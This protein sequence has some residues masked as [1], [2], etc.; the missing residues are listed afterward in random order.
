MT[1]AADGLAVGR[2]SR[3]GGEHLQHLI[4]GYVAVTDEHK[5]AFLG[6]L[7]DTEGIDLEPSAAAGFTV[8]W[9]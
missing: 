8:P 3:L 4:V 2:R 6:L 7:H 5:M 9:R 1:S